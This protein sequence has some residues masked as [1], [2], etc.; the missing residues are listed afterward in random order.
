MQPFHAPSRHQKGL[1][2]M[3]SRGWWE[4]VLDGG[5]ARRCMRQDLGY[6]TVIVY[7]TTD[8]LIGSPPFKS[9]EKEGPYVCALC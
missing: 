2:C 5:P 6:N 1:Q 9:E 7:F 4:G 8:D 3:S